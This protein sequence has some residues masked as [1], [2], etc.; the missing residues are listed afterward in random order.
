MNVAPVSRIGLFTSGIG[1]AC[2]IVEPV[3]A[4]RCSVCG[5]QAGE[6]ARFCGRC[7]ARLPLPVG[8]TFR[9]I[10]AV[11]GR[12]PPKGEKGGLR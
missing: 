3:E 6:D 11:T 4:I 10:R 2:W 8:G 5:H 1:V 12:D 7:G 9:P